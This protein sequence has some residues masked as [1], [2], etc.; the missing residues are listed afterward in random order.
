M[1]TA[2]S[3]VALAKK[4]LGKNGDKYTDYIG[5]PR[6]TD[7][8]GA[9]VYYLMRKCKVKMTV[10]G[11]GLAENWLRWGKANKRV[12][13]MKDAKPG[14]IVTF[15]WDFNHFANHVGIVLKNHRN[16]LFTC[17]EGNTGD[18][19]RVRIQVRQ[20]RF[21]RGVIRPRYDKN[22][23]PRMREEIE[24]G[25]SAPTA[26]EKVKKKPKKSG[27]VLPGRGYFRKG[28]KGDKVKHLQTWLKIQGFAP[29]K[30]DGVLGSKTVKAVGRFQK[31]HKL[32]VDGIFGKK[33]LKAAN[34]IT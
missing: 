29:G 6:G 14:D 17:I 19:A 11:A 16:G 20:A 34:K 13:K 5:F 23:K 22:K 30:I 27:I 8:C 10:P 28:D 7:W 26:P 31:K 24:S 15:D 32:T 33:C 25:Q 18:P 1:A 12:V 9:F 2:K 21:I 4:Q 3:V